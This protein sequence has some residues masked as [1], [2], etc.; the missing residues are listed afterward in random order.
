MK[1]TKYTNVLK[2]VNKLSSEDKLKLLDALKQERFDEVLT[3]IRRKTKGL[4]L[5]FKEITQEVEAV[6]KERHER[7]GRTAN[8]H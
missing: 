2:A 3:E 7:K 4:K 6:R 1:P 8:R 5:S